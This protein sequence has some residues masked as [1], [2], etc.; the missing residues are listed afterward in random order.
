M[1]DSIDGAAALGSVLTFNGC[2]DDSGFCCEDLAAFLATVG[3]VGGEATL[4]LRSGKGAMFVWSLGRDEGTEVPGVT[5]V[6]IDRVRIDM[7][8][9]FLDDAG[10]CRPLSLGSVEPVPALAL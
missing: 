2:S 1:V 9:L 3:L 5:P 7:L 10:D 4:E 8:H 6:L